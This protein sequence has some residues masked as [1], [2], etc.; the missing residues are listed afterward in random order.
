MCVNNPLRVRSRLGVRPLETSEKF[1]LKCRDE[2]L[3]GFH[4]AGE[5]L[6]ATAAAYR[7]HRSHFV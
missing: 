4:T 6:R 2:G 5:E 7:V 3:G 1:E